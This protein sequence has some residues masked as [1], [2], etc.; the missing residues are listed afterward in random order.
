MALEEGQK[1]REHGPTQSPEEPQHLETRVRLS[2][3]EVGMN[4]HS[5]QQLLSTYHVPNCGVNFTCVTHLLHDP[6][7]GAPASDDHGNFHT[8]LHW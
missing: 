6:Y 4:D 2:S 1:E 3:G 7:G 8:S 5:L